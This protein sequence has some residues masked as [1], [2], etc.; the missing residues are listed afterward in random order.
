MNLV[1]FLFLS[2]FFYH[3]H[4][5]LHKSIQLPIFHPSHFCLMGRNPEEEWHHT[6]T[7]NALERTM[8]DSSNPGKRVRVSLLTILIFFI[9]KLPRREGGAVSRFAGNTAWL[10]FFY[11]TI[12]IP[13]APPHISRI[14]SE[15]ATKMWIRGYCGEVPSIAN[16]NIVYSPEA[17]SN[18]D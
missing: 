4:H 6:P 2:L 3:F 9:C 10:W 1:F 12:R 5:F 15:K 8:I 13:S 18:Q 11:T 7:N 17:F 14:N 16:L